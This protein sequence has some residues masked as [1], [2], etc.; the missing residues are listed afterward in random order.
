MGLE[1][2]LKYRAL[3]AQ[4]RRIRED[5]P[6]NYIRTEMSTGYYD[7]PGG[8]LSR[9]HWTL[10][11]R[12][13]GERFVCTLK[14]PAQSFG[15]GEWELECDDI[16]KAIPALAALSGL[17][18]LEPLTAE[19]VT[20]RCGARFVRESL[21][22]TIGESTA[23]L[24][25]DTGVLT[26]GGRELPFAEAE[27]ELKSGSPEELLAFGQL[28]SKKYGLEPEPKSKFARA[29]ALAQEV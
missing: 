13:E 11:R 18:E 29:R 1:F 7:T 4:L 2:E 28:F 14:T 10:R 6:G 17:P 27:I 16:L 26:G 9:R 19:G 20:E 25:L 3:P 22:L 12:K 15:R 23:E 24:A 5:H 8:A 21:T